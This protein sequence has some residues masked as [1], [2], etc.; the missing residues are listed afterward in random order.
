VPLSSLH[1]SE[2]N[3]RIGVIPAI[4]ES[5]ATNG[6]YRPIV[7]RADGEI[8]A[9]NHTWKAAASLG[10]TEIA[11]VRVDVTDEQAA[12]IML[13]D[14]RTADLG[15]YD[16]AALLALLQE[17]QE[18][19]LALTGTGYSPDDLELLLGIT[20]ADEPTV[21]SRKVDPIQYV[22]TMEEPPPCAE[23]VDRTKASALLDAIDAAA[24]PE[25]VRDFLR[26]GAMRH[27]VFDYARIAEF[28]SHADA[29]V[30]ALMEASALVIVDF[31]DAIHHGFVR[32]STRL[33]GLLDLDLAD[34]PAYDAAAGRGA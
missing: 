1:P 10:W 33:Q 29:E 6:Q 30:Q 2:R 34:R 27:L 5:L 28:Y 11:V 13:A 18:V 20:E 32:L 7:V 24:I 4:A 17:V 3:P 25:E 31:D 8:L 15:G 23:L 12:R 21:Y 9:G 16:D 22:P 19:D 26:A 14:N